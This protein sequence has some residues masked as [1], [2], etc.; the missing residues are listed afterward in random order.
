MA[1][2]GFLAQRAQSETGTFHPDENEIIDAGKNAER[3]I[4]QYVDWLL[5]TENPLPPD[6]ETWIKSKAHPCQKRHQDVSESDIEKDYV[7]L[8]NTI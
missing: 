6:T 4:F 8:V 1:L 7:D 3:K 5:S 2:K